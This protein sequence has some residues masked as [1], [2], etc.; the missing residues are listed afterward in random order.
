MKTAPTIVWKNPS[1]LRPHRLI[2]DLHRYDVEEDPDLQA[3]ADEVVSQK[4]WPAHC[5]ILISP[6]N[7]VYDGEDRRRIAKRAQVDIEC[8]VIGP[9]TDEEVLGLAIKS[10]THR[11]HYTK[12]QIAMKYYPAFARRHQLSLKAQ[13]ERLKSGQRGP[14]PNDLEKV[15]RTEDL[16]REMGV[17]RAYFDFAAAAHQQFI[18]YE[19]RKLKFNE[20][21]LD[22][23][24][25]KP[26]LY[27]LRE[28]F[29]PAAMRK[30]KPIG[31]N[32]LGP[33]IASV[34]DANGLLN[35]QRKH[36]GNYDVEERKGQLQLFSDVWDELNH[37]YKYWAKFT[38][39]EKENARKAITASLSKAPDDFLDELERRLKA[40]RTRRKAS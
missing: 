34:L 11:R 7:E 30:V 12:G 32:H 37:R 25:L 9:L 29:W 26:G 36:G 14:F 38:D 15:P 39:E 40:E 13:E 23:Y 4:A 20:E 17:S 3:F 10:E 21:T 1:E 16:A 24:G 2:R 35:K 6:A 31:V 22:S 8:E 18:A 27:T 19:G 28:V 33:A 5:R